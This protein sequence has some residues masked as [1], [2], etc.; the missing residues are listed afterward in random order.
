[1]IPERISI[2]D[3]VYSIKSIE[4]RLSFNEYS[5]IKFVETLKVFYIFLIREQQFLKELIINRIGKFGFVYSE[6]KILAS[7]DN[8]KGKSR[9]FVT[10]GGKEEQIKKLNI[11]L[12]DDTNKF[13]FS[14]FVFLLGDNRN[15]RNE[16]E[17]NPLTENYKKLTISPFAIFNNLFNK[18]ILFEIFNIDKTNEFIIESIN[19]FENSILID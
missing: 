19:W 15:Y 16:F 12:L 13:I 8:E 17:K 9:D 11:D 18:D 1:K 4:S 2:G 5:S 6:D 7:V 14:Q 10:Y 3:V